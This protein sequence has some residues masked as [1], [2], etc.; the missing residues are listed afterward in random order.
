MS[1][2]PPNMYFCIRCNFSAISLKLDYKETFTMNA[3][4]V[5]LDGKA[6]D[7]GFETEII[8][9]VQSSS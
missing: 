5:I 2:V 9:D 8:R 7:F 4:Q 3:S 1:I 6:L